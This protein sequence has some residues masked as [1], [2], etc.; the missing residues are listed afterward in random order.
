MSIEVGD[1]IKSKHPFYAGV[2]TGEGRHALGDIWI[3][4]GGAKPSIIFKDDAELWVK[5]Y[6]DE[7]ERE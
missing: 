6:R 5:A 3:V 7:G 1:L 4:G 2:V